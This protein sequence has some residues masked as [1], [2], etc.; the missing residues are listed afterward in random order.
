MFV[1][2][3]AWDVVTDHSLLCLSRVNTKLLQLSSH[4]PQSTY[5]AYFVARRSPVCRSD[6]YKVFD[7]IWNC[8]FLLS[9]VLVMWYHH[10]TSCLAGESHIHSCNCIDS[11]LLL[12]GKDESFWWLCWWFLGFVPPIY[13]VLSL[14]SWLL[15]LLR[16]VILYCWYFWWYCVPR[17]EEAILC[18]HGLINTY[19]F[20]AQ[21]VELL[22]R[23]LKVAGFKPH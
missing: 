21:L 20:I 4:S 6:D 5:L 22:N 8:G 18:S 15:D 19:D 17:G 12:F 13:W 14:L 3:E 10:E 9:M 16:L 23:N 2:L 1:S 7:K 11:S